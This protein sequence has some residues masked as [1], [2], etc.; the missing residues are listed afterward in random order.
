MIELKK[1]YKSVNISRNSLKIY[2]G[3]PNIDPKS[4]AKYSKYQNPSSSGSQD[5]MLTRFFYCFDYK[6]KKGHN[7]VILGPTELHMCP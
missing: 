4:Y 6:S 2:L 1:G 5:I 3:H 7:F